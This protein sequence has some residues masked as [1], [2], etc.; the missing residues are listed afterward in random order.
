MAE[1]EHYVRQSESGDVEH[2]VIVEGAYVP[3]QKLEADR[4]ESLRENAE[5]RGDVVKS[6]SG[7]SSKTTVAELD[8]YAEEHGI[9]DYPSDGT[10]A[11]KLE[12]VKSHG[13]GS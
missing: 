1:L 2:G 6:D 4:V 12:A 10:K 3:F 8:A 9:E 5:N 11:E 7:V 13:G